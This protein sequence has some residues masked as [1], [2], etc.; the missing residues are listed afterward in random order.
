MKYRVELKPVR[1][2]KP[3]YEAETLAEIA[4]WLDA[5]CEW[6]YCG[7]DG[8]RQ[9]LVAK[10]SR[11]DVEITSPALRADMMDDNDN[12]PRV[13][14][15]ARESYGLTHRKTPGREVGP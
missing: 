15:E 11:G 7:T 8:T 5:N 4:A 13:W 6:R 3:L 12:V 1:K 10:A 14:S 9:Q 2:Y